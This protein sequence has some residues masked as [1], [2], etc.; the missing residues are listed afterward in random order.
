MDGLFTRGFH[1]FCNN[2]Y[3]SP[4]L[5]LDLFQSG[6]FLTRT[7]HENRIGSTRWFRDG[8]INNWFISQRAFI[9]I[10]STR[11]VWR[12]LKKIELLSAT[13]RATITHL[14]CSPNFPRAS[15]LNERTDDVWTNCF[16]IFSTPW[17][18][19][20]SRD[21]FADVMSV[22]NRNMKYARAIEFD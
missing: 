10:S 15:Y 6:C 11:E 8:Q 5:C 16:I 2:F 13:A 12:A 14:S 20:F 18:I 22:H 17:K 7:I 19:F 1:L 4:K 21:L 9:E 3:S